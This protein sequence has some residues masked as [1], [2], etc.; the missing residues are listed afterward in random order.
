MLI[1]KKNASEVLTSDNS[2]LIEFLNPSLTWEEK[3]KLE[4]K[5]KGWNTVYD[6]IDD[7]LDRGIDKVKLDRDAIKLMYPKTIRGE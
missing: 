7:I 2:E 6:L 1:P 5:S 3:R 4:Y